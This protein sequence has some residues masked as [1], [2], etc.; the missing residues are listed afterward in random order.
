MLPQSADAAPSA[1][2]RRHE[3][4]SWR[5]LVTA[6]ELPLFNTLR[7]WRTERSQHEGVPPY[8]GVMRVKSCITHHS[9]FPMVLEWRRSTRSESRRHSKQPNDQLL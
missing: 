1:A 8:A 2:P 7:D 5:A 6:E 3:V 4:M 9:G